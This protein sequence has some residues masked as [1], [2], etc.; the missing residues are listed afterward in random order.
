M[1]RDNNISIVLLFINN[2]IHVQCK[3]QNK[4]AYESIMK[5]NT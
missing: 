2:V 1:F 3:M 5:N 4:Y